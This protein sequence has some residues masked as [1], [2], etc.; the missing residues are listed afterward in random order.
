MKRKTDCVLW[1]NRYKDSVFV[2]RVGDNLWLF[3][4]E[5]ERP[6]RFGDTFVDPSG[7]PFVGTGMLLRDLH[8]KL[9]PERIERIGF[10]VYHTDPSGYDYCG[11]LLHTS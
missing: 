3:D 10:G 7:G 6:W 1:Q 8:P 9:P 11:W 5:N 2:R 4:C